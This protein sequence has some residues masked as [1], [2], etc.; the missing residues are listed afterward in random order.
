MGAGAGHGLRS[1]LKPREKAG[2]VLGREPGDDNSCREC[3]G[4]V[5]GSSWGILVETPGSGG[6]GVAEIPHTPHP[7]RSCFPVSLLSPRSGC[8]PKN[9][10]PPLSLCCVLEVAPLLGPLCA[11]LCPWQLHGRGGHF[12]EHKIPLSSGCSRSFWPQSWSTAQK[13]CPEFWVKAGSAENHGIRES[14]RLENKFT[15]SHH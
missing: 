7:A 10:Q 11:Q 5:C 2:E 14:L 8:S 13:S 12:G 3:S 4:L 6:S 9:E 15:A 1:A